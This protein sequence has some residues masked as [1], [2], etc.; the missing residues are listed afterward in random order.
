MELKKGRFTETNSAFLDEQGM[1]ELSL[2]TTNPF[3]LVTNEG[4][5]EFNLIHLSRKCS[6]P[7]IK[8]Y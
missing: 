4:E 2:Q 6:P 7:D 5:R 8:P 1:I 3:T